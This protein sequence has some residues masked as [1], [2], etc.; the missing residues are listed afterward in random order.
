M[1]TSITQNTFVFL[2][3]SFYNNQGDAVKALFGKTLCLLD[4]G[5]IFPMGVL[6]QILLAKDDPYGFCASLA[7]SLIEAEETDDFD[8]INIYL[9]DLYILQITH[10]VPTPKTTLLN[11]FNVH[12]GDSTGQLKSQL[13]NSY[14]HIYK[15][16]YTKSGKPRPRRQKLINIVLITMGGEQHDFVCDKSASLGEVQKD[17]C[18]LFCLPF[19]STSAELA[20][21]GRHFHEFIQK[22]FHRCKE[23][24]SVNVVFDHTRNP[25]FYDLA[26]R[27]GSKM[28]LEEEVLADSLSP[29]VL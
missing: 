5:V 26:D 6:Y 11:I 4:S 17:I 24:M 29:L 18:K 19:P 15:G 28:T 8:V 23:N 1:F 21:N 27:K 2:T 25:F 14:H 22:P 16:K 12:F 13:L 9:R 20:V 10:E 7:L 3:N